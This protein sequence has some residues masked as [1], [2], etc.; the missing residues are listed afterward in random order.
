MICRVSKFSLSYHR[1]SSSLRSYLNMCR[2]VPP[3]LYTFR[4]ALEMIKMKEQTKNCS[5]GFLLH[6]QY[7][8]NIWID[9]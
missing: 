1:S 6:Q 3:K 5:L 9:R 2:Q 7:A 8:V 4:F